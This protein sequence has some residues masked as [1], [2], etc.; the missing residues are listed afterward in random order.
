[1]KKTQFKKIE[2]LLEDL[3]N[4]KTR[5]IDLIAENGNK[6][7]LPEELFENVIVENSIFV[8]SKAS[9]FIGLYTDI[10]KELSGIDFDGFKKIINED[11]ILDN[12]IIDDIIIDIGKYINRNLTE[13]DNYIIK[14]Y[15]S[16]QVN[17]LDLKN[18]LKWFEVCKNNNLKVHII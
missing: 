9:I 4:S 8:G 12:E 16:H 1:M 15:K 13:N 14:K 7:I 18:I 11:F 2:S 5:A 10:I 17:L 3:L 6:K